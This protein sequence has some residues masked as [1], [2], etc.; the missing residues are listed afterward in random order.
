MRCI[1][2]TKQFGKTSYGSTTNAEFETLIT[3]HAF[4]VSMNKYI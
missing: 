1:Q 2:A 3:T 4:F